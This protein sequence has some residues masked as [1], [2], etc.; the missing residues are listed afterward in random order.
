M[1]ERMILG[2]T[3]NYKMTFQVGKLQRT[4]SLR[5]LK[6]EWMKMVTKPSLELQ[7]RAD[8]LFR[9][10]EVSVNEVTNV[11]RVCYITNGRFACKEVKPPGFWAR[12]CGHSMQDQIEK[13]KKRYK[14]NLI[15]KRKSIFNILCYMKQKKS[16]K[17]KNVRN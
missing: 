14:H 16:K 2:V 9:L 4:L 5:K 3:L 1:F 17:K 10:K 8:N 12:L 7:A 13:Q 15:R 11:V 6:K